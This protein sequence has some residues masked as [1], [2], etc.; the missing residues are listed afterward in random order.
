[1]RVW[2]VCVGVCVCMCVYVRAGEGSL[3]TC[4]H[5]KMG[6]QTEAYSHRIN[7][8]RTPDHFAVELLCLI[9]GHSSLEPQLGVNWRLGMGCLDRFL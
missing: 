1:M 6:T 4:V 7:F 3:Y 2:F 5:H 9:T 8:H